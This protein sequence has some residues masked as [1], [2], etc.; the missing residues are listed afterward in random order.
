MKPCDKHL[1]ALEL[2][3]LPAITLNAGDDAV[4]KVL[5]FFTASIRN[6]N[7]RLAY[8]QAIG[9]LFVWCEARGL[10]LLKIQ[11]MPV[12]AYIEQHEGSPPTVK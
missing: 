12:A 6:K 11:P 7:T 2:R 3:R 4:K 8:A 9:Q 1:L 5:E 10:N